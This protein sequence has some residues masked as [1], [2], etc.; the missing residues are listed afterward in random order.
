MPGY[1]PFIKQCFAI[2]LCLI[3]NMCFPTGSSPTTGGTQGT[4]LRDKA[5]STR[6]GHTLLGFN[7]LLKN[8]EI[9]PPSHAFFEYPPDM[10][11]AFRVSGAIHSSERQPGGII[12]DANRG[13]HFEGAASVF[14]FRCW[15]TFG[16]AK[17]TSIN[18]MACEFWG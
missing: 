2:G 6:P 8:G 13:K 14:F 17:F 1:G 7:F 15:E 18:A 5:H 11:G 4:T 16:W 10:S 9:L 3:D 12:G